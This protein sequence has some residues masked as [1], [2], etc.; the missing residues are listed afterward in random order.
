MEA[1]QEK[2]PE[3]APGSPQSPQLSQQ[4]CYMF[5]DND[6]P[7]FRY[8]VLS[9]SFEILEIDSPLASLVFNYSCAVQ[10]SPN[11][12]LIMG[13]LNKYSDA[14]SSAFMSFNPLDKTLSELPPMLRPR[15]SF[16]SV[17]LDGKLYV[18]GGRTYGGDQ[19]A[20]YRNSELFDFQTNT[21]TEIASMKERRCSFQ[22]FVFKDEI[23][24][25]GGYTDVDTRSTIIEKYN[26]KT[27]KW[28]ILP[29][30]LQIGCESGHVISIEE[31][32]VILFGGQSMV[33]SLHYCHE[34]DLENGTILNIGMLP[35]ACC[36]G[37]VFVTDKFAYVFG[38]D[39][40]AI[41][42]FQAYNLS[43]RLWETFLPS[44]LNLIMSGFKKMAV[45]TPTLVVKH[46]ASMNS[47][48][49]SLSQCKNSVFLFG[50]DD[51]PFI[52]SIDKTSLAMQILPCPLPLRLKNYQGV[53]RISDTQIFFTGGVNREMTRAS[54]YTYIL[55]LTTMAVVECESSHYTR[56]AFE[57]IALDGY[58]YAL[59]GR[60]LGEMGVTAFNKCER[61]NLLTK[62][63]ERIQSM[64]FSRSSLLSAVIHNKIYIAGGYHADGLA[65]GT[66][67][68]FDPVSEE[69][70]LYDLQLPLPIEAGVSFYD[71]ANDRWV[72]TGGKSAIDLMD[73]ILLVKP[74]SDRREVNSFNSDSFLVQS[75]CLHK[76][77][78]TDQDLVIF[79]GTDNFVRF[80]EVLDKKTFYH[81]DE[82]T[83]IFQ[84][85]LKI[86]LSKLNF[87]GNFLRPN[88][89]A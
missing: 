51:E 63:W 9:N 74:P 66:I 31:N 68:S 42:V 18:L 14:I 23:W 50:T 62:K 40:R 53:C 2:K 8:N 65:I 57:L 33:G 11:S 3:H 30:R 26:P 37:K 64:H 1:T 10:R 36:M 34:I 15:Y 87:N 19:E 43:T 84:N 60:Q 20:I 83:A 78:Q 77:F 28:T 22:A 7:I 27:N 29:F 75:R 45:A 4:Y 76:V 85:N 56:F 73:S 82:A 54:R 24:V 39:D 5:T 69:W 59:G 81:Q 88:S 52:V 41:E 61:F 48:G 38:E 25:L 72:I 71:K 46:S 86:T 55:D 79:G 21:W 32:K 35:Y 16:C 67:E 80:S 89:L 49:L 70:T 58:V 47:S 6:R 13:G 44:N 12:I 17:L